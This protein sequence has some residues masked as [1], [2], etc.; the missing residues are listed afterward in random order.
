MNFFRIFRYD[1]REK[2]ETYGNT[3]T[4]VPLFR[5]ASIRAKGISSFNGYDLSCLEAIEN[6]YLTL[7]EFYYVQIFILDRKIRAIMNLSYLLL[8]N[9]CYARYF[10]IG[11]R[12]ASAVANCEFLQYYQL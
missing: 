1:L 4:A 8:N 11:P 9:L 6:V 10:L 2:S 12:N 5:T 3:R 7:T